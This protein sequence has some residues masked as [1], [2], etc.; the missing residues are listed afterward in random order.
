MFEWHPHISTD[1]IKCTFAHWYYDSK[2]EE[3]V[4]LIKMIIF[5]YIAP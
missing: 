5:I 4:Q 3:H 1:T 2:M